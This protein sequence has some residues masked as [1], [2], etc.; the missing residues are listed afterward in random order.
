M[1]IIDLT[2]VEEYNNIFYKRD[3][4]YAP[5]GTDFVTGGKIRQ[6]RDLIGTNLDYIKNECDSTCL[7]YTSPSPRDH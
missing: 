7:L 2:P 5:Y 3:D 4:L 1:N 6:C